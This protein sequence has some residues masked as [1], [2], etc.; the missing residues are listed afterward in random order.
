M[1]PCVAR[2]STREERVSRGAVAL[3]NRPTPRSFMSSRAALKE[4]MRFRVLR[5]LEENPQAS[6]R[7]IARALGVSLGGV[8]YCLRALVEKGHVKI[9]NFRAADNKLRYAYLLT[10]KGIAEKTRLAGRFLARKMAE[11]EA[12]KVEIEALKREVDD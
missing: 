12:L 7:E 9:R 11:Y 2:S 1:L 8:N 3:L 5:F 4:D 10:P 6:Q